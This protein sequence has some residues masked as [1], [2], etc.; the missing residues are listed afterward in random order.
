[1]LGRIFCLL[2]R[3]HSFKAGRCRWC[4]R[5]QATRKPKPSPQIPFPGIE[6]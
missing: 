4:K 3:R 5:K 6:P 2:R 1:M